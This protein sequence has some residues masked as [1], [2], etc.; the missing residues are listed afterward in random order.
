MGPAT[1]KIVVTLNVMFALTT[2]VL[3]T[4]NS[5]LSTILS[6]LPPI[7]LLLPGE[8]GVA[9][10]IVKFSGDITYPSAAVIVK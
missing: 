10:P 9:P 1:S 4:T 3:T 5:T 7:H 8:S 6:T 2:V